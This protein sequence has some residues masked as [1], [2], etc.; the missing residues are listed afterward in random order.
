MLETTQPLPLL[1]S[2]Q[3]LGVTSD[4]KLFFH[5]HL[6]HIVYRAYKKST[7]FL[8]FYLNPALLR[9]LYCYEK[10]Y[11]VSALRPQQVA[12]TWKYLYGG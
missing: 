6:L 11:I 9:L 7:F 4:E 10:D 12:G 5:S 2:F 3:D 1:S 8:Q